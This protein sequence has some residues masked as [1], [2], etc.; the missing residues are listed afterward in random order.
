MNKI[1]KKVPLKDVNMVFELYCEE[2]NCKVDEEKLNKATKIYESLLQNGNYTYACYVDNKIIAVV[3]IYKNMQYYPTDLHAPYIHLECVIVDKK[4]QNMGI[5]TELISNAVNF[6]KEEGCTYI[7]GQSSNPFMQKVFY[8]A[9]LN[10]I[11]C[12]D[13][14]FENIVMKD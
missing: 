9:G 7:I 3:N 1:F 14:R 10:K 12:K 11:D 5:G 6:V 8:K 13:F 2:A 4:H